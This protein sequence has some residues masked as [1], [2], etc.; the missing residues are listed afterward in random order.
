MRARCRPRRCP[1]TCCATRC[2]SRYAE[3]DKLLGFAW[4]AFGHLREGWERARGVCDWVRDNVEYKR[5]RELAALVGD[6]RDRAPA[7]RLPRSRPRGRRAVPGAQH[8]GAL[9][10]VVHAGHRRPRRRHPGGLPRLRGGLAGGGLV[11]V[12]PAHGDRPQ[13]ARVH[14]QRAR[15]CGRRLRDAVR[16]G[17]PGEAGR[18]GRRRRRTRSQVEPRP[19]AH[20]GA[21]RGRR[22]AGSARRR[23]RTDGRRLPTAKGAC[24]C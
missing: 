10:G 2:P 17:A 20:P 23:R 4:E 14:R 22:G 11:R 19:A 6:R 1:R 3:T 9:R 24:P 16:G 12:R 15:R 13:G 21:A 8:A 5:G 7:G 18:V